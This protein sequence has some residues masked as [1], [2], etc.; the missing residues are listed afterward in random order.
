[1]TPVN[2]CSSVTID[3]DS[4]VILPAKST[5]GANTV[6]PNDLLVF[7][8]RLRVDERSA[9]PLLNPVIV[10]A[11]PDNLAYITDTNDPDYSDPVFTFTNIAL[12]EQV[13]PTLTI[14]NNVTIEGITY[15]TVLVWTWPPGYTVTPP[16]SGV[17]DI[18]IEF[19]TRVYPGTL[20]ATYTNQAYVVSDSPDMV[21][22][23]GSLQADAEDLDGDA[24]NIEPRCLVDTN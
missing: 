23:T 7:N 10:E 4:V 6:R 3:D 19:S 12:A 24:D 13:D 17:S 9:V 21:C 5:V 18:D 11:L 15:A 16:V 14:Q 22:D 1:M 8:L 20:P 2:S